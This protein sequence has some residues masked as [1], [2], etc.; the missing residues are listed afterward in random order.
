MDIGADVGSRATTRVRPALV[1]CLFGCFV[2]LLL[3]GGIGATAARPTPKLGRAPKACAAPN[4]IPRSM[5]PAA[6]NLL[7]SG[8]MPVWVHFYARFDGTANT[9][10]AEQSRRNK[11]GWRVKVL[12]LLHRDQ[13]DAVPVSII[14]V[15]SQR[16][17]LFSIAGQGNGFVSTK[18]RRPVLDPSHPGHPDVPDKPDTH[19]WGSTVYFPSAGCYT[20][21]ASVPGSGGWSFTFGFGR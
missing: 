16:A 5:P 19:E 12:W 13:R 6:F 21:R 2:Q 14:R 18:T 1:L 10:R 4:S 11:Y 15:R 20:A 9:Y 3:A 17:I 8:E 7:F